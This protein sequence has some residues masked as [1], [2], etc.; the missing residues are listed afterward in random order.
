MAIFHV[1]ALDDARNFEEQLRQNLACP[2]EIFFA[3]LTPGLSVHTGNGLVGTGFT[4][5]R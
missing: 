1:N 5:S 3:E 2:T 4:I